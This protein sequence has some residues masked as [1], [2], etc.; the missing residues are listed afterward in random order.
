MI[1]LV[2]WRRWIG[3]ESRCSS[4]CW[5]RLLLVL[6]ELLVWRVRPPR[7]FLVWPLLLFLALVLPAVAHSVDALVARIRCTLFCS[8]SDRGNSCPSP[9]RSLCCLGTAG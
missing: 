9:W 4:F 1:P 2:L 6:E 8:A 3:P 7:G 5:I